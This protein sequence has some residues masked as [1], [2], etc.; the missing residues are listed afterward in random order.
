MTQPEGD[1]KNRR[2]CRNIVATRAFFFGV[3]VTSLT[4]RPLKLSEAKLL[5]RSGDL[6]LFRDVESLT[7]DGIRFVG[8]GRDSHAAKVSWLTDEW[9]T[10]EPWCLESREFKGCRAVSLE[11]QVRAYPGRIDV[12]SANALELPEISADEAATRGLAPGE[13]YDRQGADRLAR[14]LTARPYGYLQILRTA[15][16]HSPILWACRLAANCLPHL[17]PAADYLA[18]L[19]PEVTNDT[20]ADGGMAYCS[21]YCAIVDRLGGGCD[22]VPELADPYTEPSD[23]RRSLFYHG[24]RGEGYLG[25]LEI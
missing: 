12:F 3:P 19:L 11:S 18:R 9:G 24:R 15:A 20:L 1:R 14:Q 21:A 2:P 25:T 17:R 8:R 7:S 13:Y 16:V 6:L 4:V 10:R 5:V 22:P 23:L